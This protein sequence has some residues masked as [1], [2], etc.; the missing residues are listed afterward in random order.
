MGS[1]E[2]DLEAPAQVPLLRCHRKSRA[3]VAALAVFLVVFALAC[4]SGPGPSGPLPLGSGELS[5]HHMFFGGTLTRKYV[6]GD[7]AIAVTWIELQRSGVETRVDMEP[8]QHDYTVRWTPRGESHTLW[9]LVSSRF[10]LT[11]QTSYVRRT[12][13]PQAG[14]NSGTSQEALSFSRAVVD[15]VRLTRS[16]KC[17]LVVP[18]KEVFTPLHA[19]LEAG[20]H[21]KACGLAKGSGATLNINETPRAIYEPY[22]STEFPSIK[23]RGEVPSEFQHHGAIPDSPLVAV[24]DDGQ[25]PRDGIALRLD[26]RLGAM[27]QI[28]FEFGKNIDLTILAQLPLEL[29]PASDERVEPSAPQAFPR[30]GEANVR[31]WDLSDGAAFG[32]GNTTEVERLVSA[33][34]A[35]E[36][37]AGLNNALRQQLAFPIGPADDLHCLQP[38][39]LLS[40]LLKTRMPSAD[41][42]KVA[43]ALGTRTV[44]QS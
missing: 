23:L 7:G 43:S 31:V 21:D 3:H 8:L 39:V 40:E 6:I 16:R 37:T 30:F 13:A 18:H 2:L 4:G 38:R 42:S 34:V 35:K 20:L 25:V 41:W 29:S 14:A 22:F 24:A 9:L 17:S 27:K 33:G 28:V 1:Q 15:G 26:K 36:L 12:S 44:R 19:Q 10:P 32:P 5:I 11:G